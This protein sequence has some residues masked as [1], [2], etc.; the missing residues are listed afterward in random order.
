MLE[1]IKQTDDMLS[2]RMLRLSLD[3]LV[4][5]FDLI[6]S[7]LCVVC[8]RSDHLQGDMF[9]SLVITRQPNRREM[10]PAEFARDEISTVLEGL[11]NS[12]RMIATL[13]VVFRVFLLGRV[14]GY[15]FPRR[16]R[17]RPVYLRAILGLLV[18][19]G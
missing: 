1:R 18:R 6:Y 16:G 3:D 13:A 7:R 15:V 17:W 8:R 9:P 19:Q 2:P 5:Q 11:P 10:T 14:L 4:Q 12:D